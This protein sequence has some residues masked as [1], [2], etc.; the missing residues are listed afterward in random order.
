MERTLIQARTWAPE[1]SLDFWIA[2]AEYA[3]LNAAGVALAVDT[4]GETVECVLL[5]LGPDGLEAEMGFNVEP[6]ALE[7]RLGGSWELTR[8]W[9]RC[10]KHLRRQRAGL[11]PTCTD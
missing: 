2:E 10:E 8:S 5:H 4:E 11:V 3:V 1:A 9:A 7:R 6:D